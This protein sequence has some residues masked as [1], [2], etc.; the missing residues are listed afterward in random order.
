MSGNHR[1]FFYVLLL[2]M[3][4]ALSLSVA[5]DAYAEDSDDHT[6]ESYAF[7]AAVP[8][9][10]CA[11]GG[12]PSGDLYQAPAGTKFVHLGQVSSGGKQ[13]VV[14]QFLL[15]DETNTN[16]KIF[17]VDED[18]NRKYFCLSSD[19]FE[20]YT[21]R[22][23]ATWGTSA[24]LT[25]GT[26]LMP[27]KL[28]FGAKDRPFEFTTDVSVGPTAG[29]KMRMSERREYYLIPL[30]GVGLSSVELN[31]DN[32]NGAVTEVID[33]SAFTVNLGVV[34][35]IESFQFGAFGGLDFISGP[36]KNDWKHQNKPWLA[37]GLGYNL[38]SSEKSGETNARNSTKTNGNA[39]LSPADMR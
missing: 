7:D 6:L 32:T 19:V 1:P 9:Q 27:I 26:A 3:S 29:V 33:R 4:V 8:V 36:N 18:G 14:I 20:R 11:F 13:I 21:T 24:Q 34:L 12:N 5:R 31:R 37:V 30:L 35:E 16:Y 10:Q 28:R 39:S 17:N 15:W 22:V 38:L 25:A 23:Y 2:A